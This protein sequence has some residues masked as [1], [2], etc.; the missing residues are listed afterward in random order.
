MTNDTTTLN[1]ALTELGE[2]MAENLNNKGVDAD[3]AD[4]LTTLANKILK[5]YTLFITSD[6]QLLQT[7]D[8]TNIVAT[9]P[10]KLANNAG[11]EVLFSKDVDH[12]AWT[13]VKPPSEPKIVQKGDTINIGVIILKP[14]NT[15]P[16]PPFVWRFY[17]EI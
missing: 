16:R 11:Q 17:K 12:S 6:T 7:N 5:I 9:L 3:A 8:T 13:L 10:L 15:D 1:G 14:Q 4:G 2:V